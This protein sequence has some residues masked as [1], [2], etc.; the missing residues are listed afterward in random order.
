MKSRRIFNVR[1]TLEA[2]R[3]GRLTPPDLR[4][5][6]AICEEFGNKSAADELRLHVVSSNSFANDAAPPEVRNRVA[7][8]ISA[9][10][11]MG[12]NPKETRGLLKK[13][14][15]IATINRIANDTEPSPNFEVLRSA[16]LER[17]TAEAIVLDAPD[18]FSEE[19]VKVARA[20]L[21]R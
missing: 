14:G 8:A 21:N 5:A 20:R 15:V 11:G 16:G 2:A 19:A 1:D 10:V 18:L 13:H 3:D 9:L 4:R 12:R 6:I 17:L 7:Q